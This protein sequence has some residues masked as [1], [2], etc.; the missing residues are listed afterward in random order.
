M[1]DD[2]ADAGEGRG[3]RYVPEPAAVEGAGQDIAGVGFGQPLAI[4][5][6]A[7]ERE[8][9]EELRVLADGPGLPVDAAL[10]ARGVHHEL[11]PDRTLVARGT[12]VSDAAHALIFGDRAGDDVLLA[13]VHA[14]ATGVVKEDL[15]E[16]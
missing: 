2:R 9:A 4:L 10:V 7:E 1:P 6:V 13:N 3:Q 11:R 8:A 16:L 12:L 14:L 15:V 5:E